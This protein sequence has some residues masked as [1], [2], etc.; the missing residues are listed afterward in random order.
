ML[1]VNKD[2]LDKLKLWEYIFKRSILKEIYIS[3]Y[4]NC[5]NINKLFFGI[6]RN[7]EN[8]FK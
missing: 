7:I 6:W 5:I 1:K 8:I 3:K 2:I 4:K